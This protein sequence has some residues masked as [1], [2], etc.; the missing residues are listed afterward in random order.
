MG[1]SPSFRPVSEMPLPPETFSGN[2]G[3]LGIS[4]IDR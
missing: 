2:H 1:V 3:A 4:R